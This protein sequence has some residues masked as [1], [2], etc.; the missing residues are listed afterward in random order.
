MMSVIAWAVIGSRCRMMRCV[1][2]AGSTS[3]MI[4]GRR[5][6]PHLAAGDAALQ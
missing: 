6:G 1:R 5:V 3:A 4:G 2:T